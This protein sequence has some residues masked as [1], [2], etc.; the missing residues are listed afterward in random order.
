LYTDLCTRFRSD[1]D[2]AGRIGSFDDIVEREE[3]GVV[4]VPYKAWAAKASAIRELLSRNYGD[5]FKYQLPLLRNHF[6]SCQALITSRELS[7]T[8]LLPPVEQL[9][10]FSECSR[11]IYMSATI[12]DDSSIIRTFDAS[13]KSIREP[14]VPDTLAG[15]G[16]RMIL[17][18]SLMAF[19]SRDDRSVAQE[20]AKAVSQR[21][22]SRAL[23][24]CRRS[25]EVRGQS[26]HGQRD[27][28]CYRNLAIA[29]RGTAGVR[30]C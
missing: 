15:V 21:R 29:H 9:P 3:A 10:T 30:F 17:A 22:H 8:A 12:A 1:F 6:D 16:E 4:E 18:P 25:L 24:G 13:E 11:R 20:I 28:W 26:R 5:A 23:G 14:I 7:I 2:Q 27:R 19:K